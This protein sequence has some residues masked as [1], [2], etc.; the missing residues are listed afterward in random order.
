MVANRRSI[1]D[2]LKYSSSGVRNHWFLVNYP[3][4]ALSVLPDSPFGCVPQTYSIQSSQD[5]VV[6]IDVQLD[7][8]QVWLLDE[9]LKIISRSN[10]YSFG[11]LYIRYSGTNDIFKFLN[12]QFSGLIRC[13]RRHFFLNLAQTIRPYSF[14]ISK[15][16]SYIF[17]IQLLCQGTVISC[18][19]SF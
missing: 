9:D 7:R 15:K 16:K 12:K 8:A 4:R 2:C 1:F 13:V 18:Y 17:Y 3:V 10:I 14:F 6:Q 11:Q 5:I 19:F